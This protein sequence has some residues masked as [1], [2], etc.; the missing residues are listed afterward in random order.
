MKKEKG[1]TFNRIQRQR[2]WG[3]I[4][5]ILFLVFVLLTILYFVWM[6]GL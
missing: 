2:F 5:D 4:L 3:T 1:T 6:Q